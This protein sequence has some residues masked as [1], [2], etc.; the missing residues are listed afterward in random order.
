MLFNS[1]LYI[2][3]FLP[4]ALAGFFFL[5][6]RGGEGVAICWLIGMSFVFYGWWNPVYIFLL[7]GSIVFNFLMGRVVER[8]REQP[9]ASAVLA[10]GIGCNLLVLGYFK[11]AGFF[12]HIAN[13]L[14]GQDFNPGEIVLPLAISFFTFQQIAYLVDTYKGEVEQHS[15]LRYCLFVTFFPQLIAGPIVHHAEMMPQFAESSIFRFS[16]SN[17]AVGSAI[18]IVGLFKKVCIA[19]SLDVYVTPTFA[20]AAMGQDPG[21]F[22]SWLGAFAFSLQV[23]FDF[24]GY[25]DMAIGAALLIG[26]QLP[27]NFFSPYKAASI[28]ELWRRWHMTLTRFVREYIFL[29]ISLLLARFTLRRRGGEW[30]LLLMATVLPLIIAFTLVGLWHGAGWT[31]VLFGLFHGLL[32]SVHAAWQALQRYTRTKL[33]VPE[34]LGVLLTGLLW[35]WSV[36]VFRAHD[37]A[38]AELL[39]RSMLDFSTITAGPSA[40]LY[41]GIGSVVVLYAVVMLLPNTEQLFKERRPAFNDKGM[42]VIRVASRLVWRE[43][44]AWAILLAVMFFVSAVLM[45]REVEFIYFQF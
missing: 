19:D 14:L 20:I 8:L 24:S 10:L 44:T 37:V 35:V 17:L 28:T 3:L 45:T 9:Y 25:S 36:V 12:S 13:A 29:P 41:W 7:G 43:N 39:Y 4:L 2:F 21:F 1:Y 40:H 6:R 26:I 23:Y 27:V 11:Y 31:Y 32:L 18:F 34:V 15:F 42:E 5:A 16:S 22:A 33:H 30:Q 38:S